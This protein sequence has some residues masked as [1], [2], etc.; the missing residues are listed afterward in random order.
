[1]LTEVTPGGMATEYDPE[2]VDENSVVVVADAVP[3][4]RI[5]VAAKETVINPPKS[6]DPVS[7]VRSHRLIPVGIGRRAWVGVGMGVPPGVCLH[8]LEALG[9]PR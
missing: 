6:S 4:V 1:M 7:A 8:R 9:T 3:S 2:V 5:V